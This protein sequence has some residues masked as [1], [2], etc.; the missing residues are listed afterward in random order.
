MTENNLFYGF[1]A[2]AISVITIHELLIFMF[3]SLKV[4]PAAEPWSLQPT[5]FFG[6]PKILSSLFWGGVWGV[7]YV[8]IKPNLPF[9]EPVQN[10]FIFGLWIAILNNFIVTPLLKKQPLF[11][12]FNLQAITAVLIILTG[13][14]IGTAK[15]YEMLTT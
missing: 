1:L 14:G 6:V 7:V 15:I 9:N 4:L 13:F 10:G 11:L 8:L 12:G 3:K 2:G 5:G